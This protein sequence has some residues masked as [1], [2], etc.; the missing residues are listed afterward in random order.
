STPADERRGLGLRRSYRD[1]GRLLSIGHEK[2]R[3]A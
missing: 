3:L 2:G 1:F